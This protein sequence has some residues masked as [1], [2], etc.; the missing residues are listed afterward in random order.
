MC[1]LEEWASM[2]DRFDNT[3]GIV[4][5]SGESSAFVSMIALV[6]CLTLCFSCFS[7]SIRP[8]IT[9]KQENFLRKV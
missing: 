7:T 8:N 3:W 6:S 1:G 5:E 4:K 9:D 2:P